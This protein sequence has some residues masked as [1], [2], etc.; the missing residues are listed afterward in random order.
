MDIV[1]NSNK[2]FTLIYLQNNTDIISRHGCNGNTHVHTVDPIYVHKFTR[3][4][5]DR[6]DINFKD[7]ELFHSY[8]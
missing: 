8:Q 7:I 2:I 5:I 3:L 6:I 1:K 4:F